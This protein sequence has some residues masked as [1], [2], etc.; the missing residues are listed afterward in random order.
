[1][2]TKKMYMSSESAV[3]LEGEKSNLFNVKQGVA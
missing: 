1:M 2:K 3:L